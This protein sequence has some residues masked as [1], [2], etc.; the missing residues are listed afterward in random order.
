ML[1]PRHLAAWALGIASIAAG[2][3]ACSASNQSAAQSGAGAGGAGTTT[4]ATG[5]G[6]AG[7]VTTGGGGGVLTTSSATG[8]S[9][10]GLLPDASCAAL[11]SSAQAKLQP[12]DIIIAVDTSGSMDEESAEVQANLNNFA[13]IITQSGIDVHVVLIADSSVCIP[14]PLGSGQCN[15]ADEKLPA[16]RHMLQTVASTDAFQ[17]ILATYPQWKSVLRPGATKTLAVVSDDDSAMSAADFTAQLLA[18]DPP[19]FQGFKFD[20]IVS[21]TTPD[22]C[23]FGGCFF[24][25]VACTNPCCNK[26]EFCTPLSA[27]EGTVY[28]Q[29]IMQTTGVYGDLCLQDFGPVFMDMATAVVQSAKLSCEYDIPPP[30][31]METFDPTKVNVQYT[32]GGGA[33][34]PIL[35][36]PDVGGCGMTG[37]WYYDDP[38]SPKK[39]MMCPSTCATLEADTKG[40][41]DVLFGCQTEIKPPE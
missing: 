5:V 24:N 4:T 9:S 2:I 7:G 31:D 3:A 34:T 14:A 20:G 33:P 11:S 39:I 35:N 23:I 12:A 8:S 37:G 13:T 6:G 15:G 28:K 18:L 41:I 30:P 38:A 29:L 25:C 27:A 19:T 17:Q 26:A 22:A 32:P 10:S 21:S 36:V 1:T 40:Q 16:Y